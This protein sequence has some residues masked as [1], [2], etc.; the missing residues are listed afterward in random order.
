MQ[1]LHQFRTYLLS[2]VIRDQLERIGKFNPL[3][4]WTP[5]KL[6]FRFTLSLVVNRKRL[7]DLVRVQAFMR[8]L[9]PLGRV[10]VRRARSLRG[11]SR[12]LTFSS[13]I[14]G[15]QALL[16]LGNLFFR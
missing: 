8:G 14:T 4:L 10:R 15:S 2:L 1:F 7:F 13:M 3:V 6:C 9:N 5:D 11:T 12:V 16:S